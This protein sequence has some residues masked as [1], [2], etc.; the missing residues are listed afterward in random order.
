MD[1]SSEG[2]GTL[3]DINDN[4]LYDLEAWND[5]TPNTELSVNNGSAIFYADNLTY[6]PPQGYFT[7][8]TNTANDSY[9]GSISVY[10]NIK[11]Q[12]ILNYIG[13]MIYSPDTWIELSYN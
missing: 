12:V 3:Y 1:R 6:N 4:E 5:G 13:G 11:N 10:D 8:I 9:I 7:L 2:N